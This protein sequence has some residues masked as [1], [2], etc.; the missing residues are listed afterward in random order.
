M[1]VDVANI[2]KSIGLMSMNQYRTKTESIVGGELVPTYSDPVNLE[3]AVI[4]MT[5]VE[6]RNTP[7]GLYNF[8]DKIILTHPINLQTGDII[9]SNGINYEIK[10]RLDYSD[11]VNLNKYIGRKVEVNG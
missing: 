7:E 4:P 6:L 11:F 8:E 9:I 3:C 1:I 2:I 5:G 10:T